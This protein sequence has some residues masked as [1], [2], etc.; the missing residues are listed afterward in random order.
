M[1]R[2]DTMVT[3]QRRSCETHLDTGQII[4]R[5]EA[6]HAFIITSDQPVAVRR[7]SHG[8]DDALDT[9]RNRETDAIA[10]VQGEARVDVQRVIARLLS[11]SF[12]FRRISSPPCLQR[13]LENPVVN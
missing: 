12:S 2:T 5:P 8:R 10:V 1:K 3:G 9:S 6:E 4:D 11:V 13:V 7:Q